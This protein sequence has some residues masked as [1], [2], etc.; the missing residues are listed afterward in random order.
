MLIHV[1]KGISKRHHLVLLL[2]NIWVRSRKCGCLVTWFC[3]QLIAKPGN[4]TATVSWPDPYSLSS[5]DITD[6]FNSTA[7]VKLWH[8]IIGLECQNRQCAWQINLI[9]GSNFLYHV[10]TEVTYNYFVVHRL[11]RLKYGLVLKTLSIP[12]NIA[13]LLELYRFFYHFWR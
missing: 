13:L 4:K 12:P 5:R 6:H 9:L 2:H 1:S 11:P 7:N 10:N 3:Y 8:G